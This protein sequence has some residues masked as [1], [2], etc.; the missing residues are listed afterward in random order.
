[1]HPAKTLV[2]FWGRRDS[3]TSE[4]FEQRCGTTCLCFNRITLA[5]V[6]R[7][8]W[9]G[10]GVKTRRS[11]GHHSH[12]QGRGHGALH[13]VLALTVGLH[14]Q[15]GDLVQRE[16]LGTNLTTYLLHT[17]LNEFSSS[18]SQ[19]KF[20]FLLTIISL[21]TDLFILSLSLVYLA[22]CQGCK[23]TWWICWISLPIMKMHLRNLNFLYS[24]TD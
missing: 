16:A 8:N 18:V 2:L 6:W 23:N 21:F 20:I 19:P 11:W 10:T 13:G 24:G 17:E 9:R 5:S 12:I 14:I 15:T 7:I 22:W 1:M 3:Q 4:G